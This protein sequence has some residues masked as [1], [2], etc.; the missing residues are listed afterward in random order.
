[1]KQKKKKYRF[2][3]VDFLFLDLICAF[4]GFGIFFIYVL[5]F[6]WGVLPTFLVSLFISNLIVQFFTL[7]F[8]NYN[9]I[10]SKRRK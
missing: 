6:D 8:L 3:I 9:I 4:I 10:E 2:N 1:M 5:I 7:L